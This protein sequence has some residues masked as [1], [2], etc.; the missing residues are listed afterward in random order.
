MR[1]LGG[2]GGRG[3][4]CLRCGDLLLLLRLAGSLCAS[5]CCCGGGGRLR[6]GGRLRWLGESRNAAAAGGCAAVVGDSHPVAPGARP[7]SGVGA[8]VGCLSAWEGVGLRGRWTLGSGLTG[9]WLARRLGAAAEGGGGSTFSGLG[10]GLLLARLVVAP[11]GLRLRCLC[12]SRFSFLPLR[13]LC[14]LCS[15]LLLRSL[16]TLGTTESPPASPCWSPPLTRR[17]RCFLRPAAASLPSSVATD[18]VRASV[19]WASEFADPGGAVP[20]AEVLPVASLD[21]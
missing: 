12:F 8:A 7:L 20:C 19:A 1:R 21:I 5:C 3:L 18:A 15:F 2:G 11:G 13:S 4:R 14:S 10:D 6:C 17:E 16:W 9:L